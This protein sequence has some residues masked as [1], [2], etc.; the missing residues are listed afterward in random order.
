[1][2]DMNPYAAPQHDLPPNVAANEADGRPGGGIWRD[3]KLLMM[4]HGAVLPDRCVRCNAPAAGERLK[5]TQRWRT[6]R[7]WRMRTT[8]IEVGVCRRHRVREKVAKIATASLLCV[9]WLSFA[10][11]LIASL[12]AGARAEFIS[13]VYMIASLATASLS[14]FVFAS[15]VFVHKIDDNYIWLR[16]VNR[17][18]L[19]ELPP[20][21][22]P[23]DCA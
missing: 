7:S 6:L 16:W 17:D 5:E 10:V 2:D 20:F 9:I 8:E 18:Y 23:R 1:M 14:V 15:V 13:F 4:R 11:V 3:G 22:E 12:R 21:D 19:A